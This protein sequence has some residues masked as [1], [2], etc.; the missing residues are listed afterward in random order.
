VAIS[1]PLV[2]TGYHKRLNSSLSGW[3][4]HPDAINVQGYFQND[5]VNNRWHSYK[6]LTLG[7]DRGSNW[8]AIKTSFEPSNIEVK[9]Q[10]LQPGGWVGYWGPLLI[11]SFR[12]FDPEDY[13]SFGRLES[14]ENA[15]YAQ[16]STAIARVLPTNPIAD[17]PT[18]VGEL[19]NEGLPRG[20]GSSIL[21]RRR[22]SPDEIS[23]EF[24]NYQFGIKPFLADMRA[25]GK[26]FARAEALINDYASR[27]GKKIRRRYNFSP[28]SDTV[29][30][31]HPVNPFAYYLAGLTG[32]TGMLYAQTIAGG[33][34]PGTRTDVTTRSKRTWFS[35]A[36]T[37]YLPYEGR[38]FASRLA[39]EEREMRHLYGGISVDTAWNLL[40]FSWAADWISNAGDVIHNVAAFARDGLVMP[41]GYV[42]EKS[43]FLQRRKVEGTVIGNQA[44]DVFIFDTPVTNSFGIVHQRRRRA[45]PFGFGLD[46]S[47]FTTRQ[48]SI[49]ASLGIQ[50]NLR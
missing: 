45:T 9:S 15:L 10:T 29:V 31:N 47:G 4:Q 8:T 25:F 50:S 1:E 37:Y 46:Y 40:P 12:N 27:A 30:Y 48:W 7:G 33:G 13:L 18:A 23:G 6:G 32:Q 24:L 3:V 19:F 2:Y 36:F 11:H 44:D 42:M 14:S 20:I 28:E 22:V 49:L 35:G 41:H 5:S 39:A 16:G 43:E 34:F 17:L 38:D 21:G 26:S